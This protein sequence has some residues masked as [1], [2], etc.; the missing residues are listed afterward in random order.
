MFGACKVKSETMRKVRL[1]LGSAIL[2]T[3]L[4]LAL[5]AHAEPTGAPPP[6][7]AAAEQPAA[8]A[9]PPH[10]RFQVSVS[11][12]PMAMGRITARSAGDTATA[13]GAFASGVGLSASANVFRGLMVGVVPQAIWKGKVKA[14]P[15]GMATKTG[16]D[17]QYDLLL[18][19][20][21]AYQIP[22]VATF[23]AEVMPGYS[24]LYPAT[25]DT[26][27]GLVMVYGIGGEV[28]V[29]KRL[30]ANFEVGYQMGYQTVSSTAFYRNNYVRVALG[31]G[32]RF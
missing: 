12:L 19:L 11:Y 10:P 16:T 9:A 26:S 7:T 3:S 31:M 17:T 22:G 8:D 23:F 6:A 2:T 18:R 25:T 30:F 4:A 21:Y 28:D 5:P 27:K 15:K 13:D 32:V 14:D 20:A 1:F 29:S 24:T